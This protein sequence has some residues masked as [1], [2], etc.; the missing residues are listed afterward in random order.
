MISQQLVWTTSLLSTMK[1]VLECC[2]YG[3]EGHFNG[4]HVASNP[5][6][7]RLVAEQAYWQGVGQECD[8]I[9]QNSRD[10]L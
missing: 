2:T 3:R 4:A 7:L 6:P 9:G 5:S 1:E 10:G 8:R